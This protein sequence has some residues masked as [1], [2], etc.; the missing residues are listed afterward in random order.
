FYGSQR[1]ELGAEDPPGLYYGWP[2]AEF[3]AAIPP[4]QDRL[5]RTLFNITPE[6]ELVLG[7][8]PRGLL[9]LTLSRQEA[10]RKLGI[11]EAEE[12][13]GETAILD[14]LRPIRARR[15]APP[16]DTALYVDYSSWGVVATLEASRV[17][18]SEPARQAG[19]KALDRMLALVPADGP[20]RHRVDPPPDPR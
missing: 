19:L 11:T 18:G 15:P 7:P 20:L 5:A 4:A 14:A 12:R 10:A 2:E 6:G 9:Y 8:P 1:A 13:S 3:R 16:V 17:L